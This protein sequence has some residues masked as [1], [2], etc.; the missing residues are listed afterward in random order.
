MKT[1]HK[2]KIGEVVTVFEDPIT[3][4]HPEGQA[5]IVKLAKTEDYYCVRFLDADKPEYYRF[6][7]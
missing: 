5:E 6:V 3:K 1:N 4:Q 2:Y 7:Y